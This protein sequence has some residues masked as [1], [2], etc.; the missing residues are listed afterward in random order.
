MSEILLL[1]SG[2]WANSIGR[3]ASGSEG[4]ELVSKSINNVS[5]LVQ[6]NSRVG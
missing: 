2:K 1:A 5:D 4:H 6:I 3:L